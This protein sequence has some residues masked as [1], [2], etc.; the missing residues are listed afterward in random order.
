MDKGSRAAQGSSRSKIEILG[1]Q[2]LC[3]ILI[4]LYSPPDNRF[5]FVFL[6]YDKSK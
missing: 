3:R 2:I 4:F 6:K 5:A 1:L